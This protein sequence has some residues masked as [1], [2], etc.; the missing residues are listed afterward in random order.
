MRML[1]VDREILNAV[2]ELFFL[3]FHFEKWINRDVNFIG[4]YFQR[5]GV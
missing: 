4:T 3:S 1:R 5:N 2:D